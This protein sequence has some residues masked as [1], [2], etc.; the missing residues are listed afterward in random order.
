MLGIIG[1]NGVAATNRLLQLIEEKYTLDGAFRDAH[2]PEM[3]VWQATQAPSRSMYL[4][5]RGESF[6]PDYVRIGKK[7]KEMGCTELCM[8]CNTAH[9][10]ID[11]LVNEIQLPFINIMDEVAKKA[12]E[13]KAKKVVVMCTSGLRK[14]HLYER[15][16]EKYA[17][18]TEVVYPTDEIQE[19]VTKGICN[20]K[21]TYRFSDKNIEREHPWNW[22]QKVCVH[23]INQGTAD[24]IIGGCTDIS[25]V[26]RYVGNDINYIDSLEILADTIKSRYEVKR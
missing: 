15:S 17:P 4:E 8:C 13:I 10:A 2:H 26:F 21:N 11:E 6:I 7:L 9:Y 25:N 19:W 24:C 3:I 1:G 16:F 22:F 20:A 18:N 14:F 5:G 23:Y 12:N